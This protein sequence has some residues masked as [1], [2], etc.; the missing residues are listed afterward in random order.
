MISSANFPAP[1]ARAGPPRLARRGDDPTGDPPGAPRRGGPAVTPV[2]VGVL[3]LAGDAVLPRDVLRGEA[4]GGEDL[5]PGLDEGRGWRE[6]M[7]R[8]PGH[9]APRLRPAG[10]DDLGESCHDV[11]RRDGDGPG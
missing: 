8:L 2:R 7:A 6:R 1:A 10:P 9:Q 3:I 5:G 4:H 11:L